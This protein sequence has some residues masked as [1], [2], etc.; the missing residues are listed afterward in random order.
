MGSTNDRGE[1]SKCICGWTVLSQPRILM[2]GWLPRFVHE[3]KRLSLITDRSG[4][5]IDGTRVGIFSWFG[6]R[7]EGHDI[8]IVGGSR[9]RS[10]SDKGKGMVVGEFMM[11]K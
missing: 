3:S 7:D 11:K 5:D 10:L 4:L 1:K 6:G 8:I 2:A 9:R